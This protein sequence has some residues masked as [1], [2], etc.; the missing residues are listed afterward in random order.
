M[1]E[2]FAAAKA[3]TLREVFCVTVWAR[4]QS[5]SPL[6]ASGGSVA[7]VAMTQMRMR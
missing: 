3:G 7:L 4:R 5:S 2:F 1:S 6:R